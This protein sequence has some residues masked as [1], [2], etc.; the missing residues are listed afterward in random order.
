MLYISSAQ[1]ITRIS[2]G[3]EELSAAHG[4]SQSW[5]RKEIRLGRLPVTR[6]GRRVVVLSVDLEDFLKARRELV[7]SNP[8]AF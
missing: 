5:W 8:E 2:Y 3:I 1:P 7:T 4:N 6:L